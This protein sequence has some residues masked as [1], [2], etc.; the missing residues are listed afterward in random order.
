MAGAKCDE[1][2]ITP[3]PHSPALLWGR[4]K[5]LGRREEWGQGVFKG[6]FH[7]SLSSSDFVGKKY[8]QYPLVESVLSAMLFGEWPLS[9]LI[10]THEPLLYFLSPVQLWRGVI[11]RLWWCVATSLGPPTTPSLTGNHWLIK[12]LLM[13][14]SYMKDPLL[15]T[16]PC[17]QAAN[18]IQARAL[19]WR[20]TFVCREQFLPGVCH[21]FIL[22]QR[23]KKA[24]C[25]WLRR[26]SLQ[27]DFT[28]QLQR[29]LPWNDNVMSVR[30]AI[31]SR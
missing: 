19:A 6:L 7:F 14:R 21:I 12:S 3:I 22:S 10:S 15:F 16:F 5:S 2:S 31:C 27:K 17:F 24:S 11:E 18:P 30:S 8:N 26:S 4:R 29:M 1:L 13:K 23:C 20:K 25:C 28:F 9:V